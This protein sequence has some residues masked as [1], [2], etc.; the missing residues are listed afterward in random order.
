MS[1]LVTDD[2]LLLL[3]CIWAH[4]EQVQ[5]SISSRAEECVLV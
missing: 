4:D 2:I 1:L 5:V 3:F